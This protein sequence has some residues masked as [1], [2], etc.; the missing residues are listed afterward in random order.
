[1]N[2]II[3]GPLNSPYRRAFVRLP[4]CIQSALWD[5]G[6]S[7]TQPD[8]ELLI[9]SLTIEQSEQQELS[10]WETNLGISIITKCTDYNDLTQEIRK[11]KHQATIHQLKD[12]IVESLEDFIS[13]VHCGKQT[14]SYN[15]LEIELSILDRHQCLQRFAPLSELSNITKRWRHWKPRSGNHTP[16]TTQRVMELTLRERLQERLLSPFILP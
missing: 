9:E 11:A 6:Y 14:C 4:S 10:L 13:L 16:A 2:H 8:G 5:S 7:R 12:I 15:S 1:M 3:S